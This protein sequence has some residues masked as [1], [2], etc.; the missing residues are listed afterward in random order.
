M[1]DN[2]PLT[3]ALDYDGT[4]TEMPLE[5]AAALQ[6][7][8]SSGAVIVGVTMRYESEKQGMHQRYFEVCDVVHFTGRQAKARFCEQHNIPIHIWIDDRPDFILG[9]AL[10]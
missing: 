1:T 8:K 2:S 4:F 7:L 3:I 10:S 9:D 5:W 6:I